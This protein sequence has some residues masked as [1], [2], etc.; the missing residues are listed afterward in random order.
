[1]WGGAEAA[2]WPPTCAAWHR[3]PQVARSDTPTNAEWRVATC[4]AC[5]TRR[6]TLAA[7]RDIPAGHGIRVPEEAH[8]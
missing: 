1:M 5:R 3:P 7:S 2:L 6:L 8:R 4:R